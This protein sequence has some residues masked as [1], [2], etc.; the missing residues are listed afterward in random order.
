MRPAL[1]HHFQQVARVQADDGPSVGIEVAD[2]AQFLREAF[3]GIQVRKID[4]VVDFAHLAA[5][6][7]NGAD[8][9]LEHKARPTGPGASGVLR[10][11]FGGFAFLAQT[12]QAGGFLKFELLGHFRPPGRV[13]DIA[14]A[15]NVQ[16]LDPGPGR[17]KRQRQAFAGGPRKAGVDVQVRSE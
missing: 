14:R 17:Q 15:Q 13:G 9:A 6:L 5:A 12:V 1:Q 3:G 11:K 2:G 16:A 8:L 4:Q 7:V 10:Q